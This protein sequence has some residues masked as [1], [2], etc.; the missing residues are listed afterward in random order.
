[1]RSKRR[2]NIEIA[3]SHLGTPQGSDEEPT[4]CSVTARRRRAKA[5]GP[6]QA[7]QEEQEDAVTARKSRQALVKTQMGNAAAT[8][9]SL[10]LRRATP[11]PGQHGTILGGL[12][13]ESHPVWLETPRKPSAPAAVRVKS[14]SPSPSSDCLRTIDTACLDALARSVKHKAGNQSTRLEVG[15]RKDIA[16]SNTQ[17]TYERNDADDQGHHR[18]QI[19]QDAARHPCAQTAPARSQRLPLLNVHYHNRL[20]PPRPRDAA[21]LIQRPPRDSLVADVQVRRQKQKVLVIPR[22]PDHI[23]CHPRKEDICVQHR[24]TKTKS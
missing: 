11:L 16:T 9:T 8:S 5:A 3:A 4:P 20:N 18:S 13:T 7:H 24:A 22:D 10:P 21:S 19:T 1:M 14:D 15:S 12:G 2:T 17:R 6:H 23:P